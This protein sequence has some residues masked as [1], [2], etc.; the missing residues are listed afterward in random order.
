MKKKISAV[1]LF[2]ILTGSVLP[3][4][5]TVRAEKSSYREIKNEHDAEMNLSIAQLEKVFEVIEKMPEDILL[6][7]DVNSIYD[8]LLKNGIELKSS[9]YTTYGAW[10]IAK[11]VGAIAW[12]VGST[13]FAATKILKIKKYIKTIGGIRKAAI[14]VMG[15]FKTGVVPPDAGEKVGTAIMNLAS[16]LL[17]ITA[18]KDNCF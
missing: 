18:I 17:G 15:F 16:E 2:S 4:V 11:C 13:V 8:Y 5:N 3:C 1:L 6:K 14:L 9:S 12:V 7:N 10:E